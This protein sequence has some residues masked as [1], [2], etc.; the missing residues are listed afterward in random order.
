MR[1]LTWMT[2]KTS[3]RAA[4][5]E[6]IL[7]RNLLFARFRP[8]FSTYNI[9]QALDLRQVLALLQPMKVLYTL[10]HKA[11]VDCCRFVGDYGA[12]KVRFVS[13]T[14]GKGEDGSNQN[15]VWL[16]AS[17]GNILM[18]LSLDMPRYRKALK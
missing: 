10:E 3:N 7:C 1:T 13:S 11:P 15:G 5:V 2:R 14:T 8:D 6:E 4:K 9:D 12:D 18:K 16:W 17:D